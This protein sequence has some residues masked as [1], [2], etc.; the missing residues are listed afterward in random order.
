MTD[1]KPDICIIATRSYVKDIEECLEV[2]GPL[3]INTISIGEEAFYSWNSAPE[4]TKKYDA[5]YKENNAT[6]TGAGF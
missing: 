5:L 6:F 3:G 4:L 2:L 1:P